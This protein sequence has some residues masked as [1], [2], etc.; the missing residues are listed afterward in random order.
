MKHYY[1]VVFL[2]CGHAVVTK[3]FEDEDQV[4][5]ALKNYIKK[6]PTEVAATTYMAREQDSLMKVFGNPRSRNLMADKKFMKEI[7]R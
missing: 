1:G 5:Q 3:A 2:T 6:H 7:T 4:R